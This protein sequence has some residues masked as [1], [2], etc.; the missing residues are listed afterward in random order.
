MSVSLPRLLVL[1]EH[2]KYL[3]IFPVAV[4]EGPIISVISGFL[5]SLRFINGFAIYFILVLGD[6]AGDSLHYFA[7]RYAS[8]I[9]WIKKL[10]HFFGYNENSQKFLEKH[11]EKHRGKTFLLAKVSHGLGGAV[12]VASGIARVDYFEF[13]LF[14]FIG[15]LPKALILMLIGFYAG[16]SYVK[17]NS[18]LSSIG[19]VTVGIVAAL[20]VGYIMLNKSARKHFNKE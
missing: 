6:V 13:L 15:T 8:R 16:S 3:L 20:I 14:N 1:F 12:Q 5:V 17:I 4:F 9:E 2:Y 11:F 7:G 18:Y 10:T 19:F